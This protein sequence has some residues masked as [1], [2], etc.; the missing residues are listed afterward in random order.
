MA[1]K[2][3]PDDRLKRALKSKGIHQ[4]QAAYDLKIIQSRFNRLCLGW[5]APDEETKQRIASYLGI[6]VGA[7][8]Q[9]EA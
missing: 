1:S 5:E 3:F 6:T 8:W 9:Q 4:N 7:I 2:F